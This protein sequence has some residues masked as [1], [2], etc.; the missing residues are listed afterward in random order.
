MLFL[1]LI[2]LIRPLRLKYYNIIKKV[3]VTYHLVVLYP[4]TF[5]SITNNI[6][7]DMNFK[8]ASFRDFENIPGFNPWQMPA[9]FKQYLDYLDGLGH[10]NYRM[11]GV[12][13][14]GPEVVLERKGFK[15]RRYVRLVSN[16]Y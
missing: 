8:K 13:N 14:L 12:E 16:D 5:V 15:N 3:P 6:H 2:N 1:V 7:M 9:L 10:L 11:K 4:S